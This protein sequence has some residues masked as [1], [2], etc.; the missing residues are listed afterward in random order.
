M[1]PL[2]I[3]HNL[4]M[5][6][7]G[8][9]LTPFHY[10]RPSVILCSL[11][12]CTGSCLDYLD[13]FIEDWLPPSRWIGSFSLRPWKSRA[14]FM[15]FAPLQKGKGTPRVLLV[16]QR[17]DLWLGKTLILGGELLQCC[18]CYVASIVPRIGSVSR[19][20]YFWCCWKYFQRKS[21]V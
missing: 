8:E 5:T 1:L 16:L 11:C 7:E 12:N 20:I 3:V 10:P 13:L 9:L 6:V 18:C 15:F 21:E 14:G 2:C 17:N 4:L 19:H